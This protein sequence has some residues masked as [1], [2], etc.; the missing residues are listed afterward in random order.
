FLIPPSKVR[1]LVE[2]DMKTKRLSYPDVIFLKRYFG[3]SAPAMLRTLRLMNY[4]SRSQFEHYFKLDHEA[5]E[6]AVFGNVS[7]EEKERARAGPKLLLPERFY[8]LKKEAEL[9]GEAEEE[10]QRNKSKTPEQGT[11]PKEEPER[12]P[13]D[14]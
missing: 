8:L 10:E 2:K 7:V 13:Q 4:L 11:E 3:V 6:Q 5:E 12:E 14:S 1:E 9:A